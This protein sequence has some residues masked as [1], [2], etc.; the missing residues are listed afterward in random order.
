MQALK[1]AELFGGARIPPS[2]AEVLGVNRLGGA[3]QLG[4]GVVAWSR[5]R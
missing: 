3:V 5:H 1:L 4:L 2:V